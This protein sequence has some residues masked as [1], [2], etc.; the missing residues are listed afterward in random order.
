VAT[1]PEAGYIWDI[2]T[3]HY[4]SGWSLTPV[5]YLIGTPPRQD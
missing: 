4:W 5:T 3:L 2:G 1:L